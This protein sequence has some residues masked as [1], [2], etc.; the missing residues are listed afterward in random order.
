MRQGWRYLAATAV[1]VLAG[2]TSSSSAVPATSGTQAGTVRAAP[3]LGLLTGNFAHG[4]GFGQV[5]PREVFNGGD[6]TGLVTSITWHSWGGAQAVGT[7]RSD[8]VG[9]NQSVAGGTLE[10]VRIVAFDLGTCNGRYM[11]AAVEWY[12]P[13]H[14]QAFS[15]GQFE[16]ACIGAYYPLTTGQYGEITGPHR[17]VLTL[18][19]T[20]GSLTGSVSQIAGKGK[21]LHPLF[22]FH[23]R[24]G[25]DGSLALV[26]SGPFQ[27]GRTF[28]GSWQVLGATLANCDSYLTS[29]AP[30]RPSCAFYWGTVPSGL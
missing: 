24:A 1:V 26:S 7:G 15:A 10:P 18:S 17:Y 12:F 27:P 2:C 19:G 6:P 30:P 29:A 8:Y 14:G 21:T 9:P 20:P 5:K 11:Y 16:D 25:I 3:T 4:A 22:S 23:G 28:T 13:Q